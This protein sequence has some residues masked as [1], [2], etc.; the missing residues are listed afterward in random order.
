ML[1]FIKN[2]RADEDGAVTVDW[3]VL[4]A[5]AMVL[6]LLVVREIVVGTAD[7]ST[8]LGAELAAAEPPPLDFSQ[9]TP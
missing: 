4:T 1:D 9:L 2:F 3:V 7:M 6:G 5:G 8:G